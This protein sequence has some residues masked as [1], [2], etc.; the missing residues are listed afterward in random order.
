MISGRPLRQLA[1]VGEDHADLFGAGKRVDADADTSAV[2]RT[3]L[4]TDRLRVSGR[5][6]NSSVL[7]AGVHVFLPDWLTA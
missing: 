2:R 7:N 1:P 5:I 3:D 4:F 6:E